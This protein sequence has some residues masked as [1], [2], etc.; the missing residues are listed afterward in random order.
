M[1]IPKY[2]KDTMRVLLSLCFL[3]LASTAF[4]ATKYVP[5]NDSEP[6]IRRDLLP[7]DVDAIREVAKNL[8]ILADGPLPKPAS[9]VR[10]RAQALT[11]S[12]RLSP[13][14]PRARAVQNAFLNGEDRPRPDGKEIKAAKRSL[15]STTAYLVKLP[16]DSEGYHLGQLILDVLHQVNVNDPVLGLRDAANASQRWAGVVA[17][18]S[19]FEVRS[20]PNTPVKPVPEPPVQSNSKYAVTALLTEIPMFTAGLEEGAKAS[21]GLITT[22]LV[23][24]TTEPTTK[25]D[26][27]TGKEY[28]T[29]SDAL[30]FQPEPTFNIT[31]LHGALKTFFSQNLEPLPAGYT[32]NVNTNKRRYLSKN[33]ENI[34]APLAMMLDAAVTGRPLRRNTILFGRL[35]A[36]GSLERPVSAWELLLRLEELRL[37]PGTRLIVG[38]GLM[39]E[40]TAFLVV[41]KASFFTKYEVIEVSSFNDARELFYADGKPDPGLTSSMAG[42][43]EVRDK[44]L[45]A[46]NLG[47]FLSLSS[48]EQRLIKARD[49]WPK[50]LSNSLLA[51]Q[52][53]RRPAYFTR[54]MFAQELDRRLEEL[55]QFEYV[56]DKTPERAIKDAY[57]KTRETLDP[58]KRRLQRA[59]EA[60]FDDAIILV[61]ELL[62]V[63]RGSSTILDNKEFI[64]KRDMM[65]FQ[66][67]LADFR[68]KLRQIYQP[69]E[70]K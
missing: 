63:G 32:L 43:A 60:V 16:N 27:D 53:I 3:A 40:M 49:L 61:K 39:E 64:R 35:R 66:K 50:H 52:A 55:S 70:K 18:V 6:L 29:K 7:L 37:A 45:Q 2:R 47:T 68:T 65:R 1:N 42:Y 67:K 69:E 12:Q 48:V 38:S 22:S 26:P 59:E 36:D 62:A 56:I 5:S 33:R 23:I 41:E 13:A 19:D 24:T 51:E 31:P 54:F 8:A 11:L 20:Q 46:N 15:V 9:Q 10:N 28:T 58:M 30:R 57:K 44:A 21:C 14:E 34:A 25:K 17:K 4:A